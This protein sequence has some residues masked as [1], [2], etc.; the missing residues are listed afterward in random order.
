MVD[1][2]K[3]KQV[4]R[5]LEVPDTGTYDDITLAAIKNY[6]LSSELE[7]ITYTSEDL[8]DLIL[9]NPEDITTDF[10]E[11]QPD[12]KI[13][14]Y[15]LP[16]NEYFKSKDK[17][18]YIFLHHTAGWNNPKRQIDIWKNDDRGR[19]G[20]QYVIGGINI[21]NHDAAYDGDAY[22]AFSTQ[23]YAWH[24]GI[25][26]TAMHRNSIGIEICNFG[27]AIPRNDKFYTY[28]GQMIP[29]EYVVKIDTEFRGHVYWH[30]YTDSQLHTLRRLLLKIANEEGIDIREGLVKALKHTKKFN[31]AF[32]F[33]QQYL[34]GSVK[35][36][37]SHSNVKRGKF[38]VS[39]QP[40]LIEMLYTL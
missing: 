1:I 8:L 22:A 24:L 21:S 18:E 25:G 32:E 23:G 15:H 5:K 9:E 39:P 26:N 16:E 30:E 7:S 14:Q 33:D 28:T 40:N 17:K 4:Q 11:T 37:L 3:L 10:H 2:H 19:L 31:N 35:G 20:T 38:D 12:L 29:N 36:L 27:Y 34:N 13:I 6:T